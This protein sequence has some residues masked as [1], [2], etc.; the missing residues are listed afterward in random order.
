MRKWQWANCFVDLNTEAYQDIWSGIL[1][2]KTDI[3]RA[4]SIYVQAIIKH[5][6][7]MYIQLRIVELQIYIS[8]IKSEGE[9][10]RNGKGM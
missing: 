3:N 7:F 10:N 6:V 1:S 4:G 5:I 8:T 9:I 2:S